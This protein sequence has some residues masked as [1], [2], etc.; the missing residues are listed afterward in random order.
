MQV[1]ICSRTRLL[2]AAFAALV[3]AAIADEAAWP[4]D[5]SERLAARLAAI[6]P[7]AGQIGFSAAESPAAV[8][9]FASASTVSAIPDA[10]DAFAWFS[11]LSDD[12]RRIRTDAPRGLFL[13]LR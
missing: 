1:V 13:R 8:D 7:S 4:S 5:F 3:L 2:T 9:A 12:V 6:A 10:V 11:R